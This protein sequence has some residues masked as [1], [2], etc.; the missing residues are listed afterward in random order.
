MKDLSGGKASENSFTVGRN[1]LVVAVTVV[2]QLDPPSFVVALDMAPPFGRSTSGTKSGTVGPPT[3]PEEPIRGGNR[4][5]CVR[6]P[7][8]SLSCRI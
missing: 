1:D 6:I 2:L 3:S 7:S 5:K 8:G 4:D